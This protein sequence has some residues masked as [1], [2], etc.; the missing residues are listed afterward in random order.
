MDMPW[1]APVTWRIRFCDYRDLPIPEGPA[2]CVDARAQVTADTVVH[3]IVEA[4]DPSIDLGR[5]R[6]RP[7]RLAVRNAYVERL[8]GSLPV[9]SLDVP[10]LRDL[11]NRLRVPANEWPAVELVPSISA[12]EVLAAPGDTVRFVVEVTNKGTRPVTHA[13]VRIRI[14]RDG[15]AEILRDWFPDL[16]AGQ[17]SRLELDARLPTGRATA[18]VVAEPP[19]EA[20]SKLHP[21]PDPVFAV[22]G[23]PTRRRQ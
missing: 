23:D 6:W 9:D 1:R 17:S 19:V 21:R 12:S 22:V 14:Q 20:V 8:E 13:F 7:V 15:D 16:G 5:I 4:A 11:A 3:V 18:V 10:S 2:L